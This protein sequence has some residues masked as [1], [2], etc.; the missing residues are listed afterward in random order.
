MYL[1]TITG[2]Y[3]YLSNENISEYISNNSVICNCGNSDDQCQQEY[4]CHGCCVTTVWCIKGGAFNRNINGHEIDTSVPATWIPSPT[5]I[6]NSSSSYLCLCSKIDDWCNAIT[7]AGEYKCIIGNETLVLTYKP[8]SAT[9]SITSSVAVPITK[10]LSAA[11]SLHFT[12]TLGLD[13]TSTNN[14]HY[15]SIQSTQSLYDTPIRTTTTATVPEWSPS[16]TP[17]QTSTTP[18]YTGIG[19]LLTTNLLTATALIGSIA[20]ILYMRRKKNM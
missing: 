16:T 3:L 18:H 19:L 1:Y 13:Y 9:R 4:E 12:N 20:Y 8:S 6:L 17:E 2:A 15:T 5:Q 14:L 10:S 11:Q 7:Q